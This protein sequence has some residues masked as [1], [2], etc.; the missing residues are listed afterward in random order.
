MKE[1][2]GILHPGEMGISVAVS[3]QMSGHDVFWVSEGRSA[4]TCTRAGTHNL[5]DAPSLAELCRVCSVILS[6]CP[7]H[8]AESVAYQVVANSFRGLFADLNAISPETSVRIARTM[9]DEGIEYV[10]GGIIGGPAW[11]ANATRLYL[12]GPVADRIAD[13]FSSGLLQ[14]EVIGDQAGKASALKMCYGAYTKGTTALLCAIEAAAEELGVR[15]FL[16]K[17][18]GRDEPG[19][20]GEVHK[21]MQR[22]TAK[23][24]RFVGEMEEVAAT[25]KSVNMPGGFHMAASEIYRGL[26]GYRGRETDPPLADILATLIRTGELE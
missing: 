16:E 2:V 26:E 12:S 6:I 3:A 17:E 9:S 18:W 22:V 21:R 11:K 1:T 25:F 8:A 13:C 7:P 24:W 15:N 20:P 4:Q 19:F 10:D 23:A 5:A 14:V